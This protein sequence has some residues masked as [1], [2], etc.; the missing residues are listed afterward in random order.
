[1]HF[2]GFLEPHANAAHAG[3]M[4]AYMKHHFV[5]L[6]IPTPQRREAVKAVLKSAKG[7]SGE[8]LRA[9]AESLWLEPEREFHYLAIDIL[10]A[11]SSQL[12]GGDLPWIAALCRKN[13]WWDSIDALASVVNRMVL[14]DPAVGEDVEQWGADSDF[15]MRRVVIL[16]QRHSKARTDEARLFRLCLSNAADKEFF[17]R[18]GIGWALREYG[19]TAPE[20][21]LNFLK[22]NNS[23]LSPLTLREA[24]R[25]LNETVV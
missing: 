23:S 14:A 17:I 5:Y 11:G 25:R 19:K 6:G 24:S 8:E 12:T 1:M 21:V 4:A 2:R 13:S 15:W 16:H 7:W 20:A 18:K 9:A 10:D 3:P 22:V